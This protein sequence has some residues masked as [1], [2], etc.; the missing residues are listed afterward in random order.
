MLLSVGFVLL[1]SLPVKGAV[2]SRTSHQCPDRVDQVDHLRFHTRVIL[3]PAEC[4]FL[5]GGSPSDFGEFVCVSCFSALVCQGKESG[6]LRARNRSSE[7]MAM[8]F[9]SS[10]ETGRV[11]C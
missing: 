6:V 8:A 4:W 10:M 2:L 9:T 11:G 1:L 5:L 3:H 7:R